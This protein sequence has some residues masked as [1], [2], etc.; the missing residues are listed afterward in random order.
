MPIEF[1]R[2][3]LRLSLTAR[4]YQLIYLDITICRWVVRTVLTVGDWVS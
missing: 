3:Y 1:G 2:Y 4:G